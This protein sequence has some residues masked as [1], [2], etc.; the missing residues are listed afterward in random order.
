ME[1]PAGNW[2][3]VQD[4]SPGVSLTV[5][6]KRGE[7]AHGNFVRLSADSLFLKVDANEQA[8][9]REG[10]SQVIVSRPGS[11]QRR[12][13]TYG[14][15]FFGIG[16]GLGWL[17]EE[18]AVSKPSAGAIVGSGMLAG[19]SIGGIAAALASIR[20]PGPREEVIYRSK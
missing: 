16:F 10:I 15:V 8:F 9:S 19:A 6:L 18:V 20:K 5:V 11:R 12:A 2:N 1:P 17:A 3:K 7:V 4:L 13:A 14:G